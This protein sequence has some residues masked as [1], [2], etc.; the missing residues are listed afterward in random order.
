MRAVEKHSQPGA[1]RF[2]SGIE[3]TT[4]KALRYLPQPVPHSRVV[5][6]MTGQ[7]HLHKSRRFAKRVPRT[8]FCLQ[9]LH[10][11]RSVRRKYLSNG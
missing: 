11:R 3:S 10:L 7:E 5:D 4:L 1:G 9:S 6:A 2:N 8:E